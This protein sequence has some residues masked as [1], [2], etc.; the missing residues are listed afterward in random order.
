DEIK[1]YDI[2]EWLNTSPRKTI[3]DKLDF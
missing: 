1:H 3:T 2:E